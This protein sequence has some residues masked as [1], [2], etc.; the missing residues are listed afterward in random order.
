MH[1]AKVFITQLFL[2]LDYYKD[3]KGACAIPHP[4]R[5]LAMQGIKIF[6]ERCVCRGKA[7]KECKE[8]CDEDD[9]CRGFVETSSKLPGGMA[10]GCQYATTSTECAPGCEKLESDG[11]MTGA[12]KLWPGENGFSGYCGCWIKVK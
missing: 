2:F 10:D 11:M 4:I 3:N 9:K 6:H 7:V 5:A 1:S 12:D 8:A